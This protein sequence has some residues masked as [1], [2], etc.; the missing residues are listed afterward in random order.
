MIEEK[1]AS[2]MTSE[3]LRVSSEALE[4]SSTS[5][6]LVI[7]CASSYSSAAFCAA[8]WAAR[9]ASPRV[10]RSLPCDDSR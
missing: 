7:A 10:S 4:T 1:T 3:C 2:T 6:A 5:S 9:N 8:S